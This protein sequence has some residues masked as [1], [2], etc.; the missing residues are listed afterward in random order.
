MGCATIQDQITPPRVQAV[1][2]LGSYLGVKTT[3]QYNTQ[4]SIAL[5]ALVMLQQSGNYS[6][7]SIAQALTRT[8]GPQAA[9]FINSDEGF[10]ILQGGSFVFQDLWSKTGQ[11]ALNN[12]Y[13]KAVLDGLVEGMGQAL[14]V[15][16]TL[17][18]TEDLNEKQLRINCH[19]TRPAP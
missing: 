11:V 3:P 7:P 18:A 15:T 2:A 10:I 6:F 19:T 14:Q 8:L 5:S 1:T 12:A 13:A 9:T 4:Y 17:S 16:R